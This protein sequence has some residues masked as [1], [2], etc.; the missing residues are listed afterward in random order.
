M[1]IMQGENMRPVCLHNTRKQHAPQVSVPAQQCASRHT[2]PAWRAAGVRVASSCE[3]FE[4]CI[5]HSRGLYGKLRAVRSQLLEGDNSFVK[6]VKVVGSGGDS[7]R[8]VQRRVPRSQLLRLAGILVQAFE[9][10][11]VRVEDGV[12]H[13]LSPHTPDTA[14]AAFR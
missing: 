9:R 11:G 6:M 5:Y 2:D 8:R 4:L 13:L 7:Q 10:R 12:S 1:Y 3:K 14:L